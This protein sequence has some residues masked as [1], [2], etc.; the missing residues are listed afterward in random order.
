MDESFEFKEAALPNLTGFLS[1]R[2]G[3]AGE[4]LFDASGIFY[5][6][7][8]NYARSYQMTATD[9]RHYRAFFNASRC[10]SVYKNDC[11]TVQP[12][13]YTV[14][15]IMKIMSLYKVGYH[16]KLQKLFVK[17]IQKVVLLE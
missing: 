5:S 14:I 17:N 11:N 8:A 10:S 9:Q 13:A 3:H 7:V 1:F 2:S 15:Y 6:Q 12:P 16:L 4:A